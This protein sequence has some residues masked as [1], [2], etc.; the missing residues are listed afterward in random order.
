M[1]SMEYY[2][3]QKMSESEAATCNDMD[4]HVNKIMSENRFYKINIQLINLSI[5]FQKYLKLNSM[6]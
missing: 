1:H 2:T 4:E 3:V 5:K 6:F